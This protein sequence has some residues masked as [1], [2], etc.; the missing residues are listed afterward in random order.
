MKKKILTLVFLAAGVALRAATNDL[1]SLLQQGLFDEEA[2]H[3]LTS[4]IADYQSLATQFDRDRQVAATAIYRLGECYR[5]LGKSNEAVGE[6]QRIIKEFGEQKDLATL[7]QQNLAGLG[8]A[9]EPHFATRLNKLV[10][11]APANAEAGRQLAVV[12]KLQAMQPYDVVQVAPTLLPDATLINLINQYNQCELDRLRLRADHAETNAEVLKAMAIRGVMVDKIYER[13]DGLAKALTIEIAA[14]GYGEATAAPAE[15]T[16]R[17]VPDAE[18]AEIQNIQQMIQNSP[19]LINAPGENQLTPLSKAAA[20]GWLKVAAYLL[21][22]GAEVNAVGGR[23]VTALYEAARAGNRAMVELLLSRGAEVNAG[24]SATTH[25]LNVAA[26][27]GFTAVVEVLLANKADVNALDEF[28]NTPLCRAAANSH[29]KIIQMLLTAG[30]N[31]N[32][33]NKNAL[34]PLMLAAQKNSPDA[35]KLLL[36]AGANPNA[37]DDDG[38]CPLGAAVASGS[39]D[40]VEMLLAAKADPNGGTLDTPLFCAIHQKDVV[41]AELLLKAG[42][43]PNAFGTVDRT[44]VEV[45]SDHFKCTPLYQAI[46]SGQLPMVQLLLKFKADPNNAQ[47]YGRPLLFGALSDTNILETMLNAGATVDARDTTAQQ[48]NGKTLN[49]TP[50]IMAVRD[51]GNNSRS[52]FSADIVEILLRHGANPNLP[53]DAFGEA[54]LYWSAGWGLQ[55]VPNRKI[56]ELLLDYKADPNARNFDGRTLLDGLKLELKNTSASD[57][58]LINDLADL[59]RQHGALDYLPD[60]DHIR[61][62]RLAATSWPVL[63]K[64]TNDWNQFTLL[65]LVAVEC[66]FLAPSPGSEITPRGQI[67]GVQDGAYDFFS[68]GQPLPFPDLTRLRIRRPASDLKNTTEQTVDLAAG[69]QSGD[70]SRDTPLKWADVVEIPEADHPINDPWRGFS[71]VEL[72]NIKKCLTRHIEIIVKGQT[73]AITLAPKFDTG[74]FLNMAHGPT[75]PEISAITEVSFWLG[76]VL[77]QSNL[78]LASSDL[79]QVKVTRPDPATG[80]AR[81]WTVD[82]SGLS[83][84]NFNA[85]DLWLRD[86]DVVKV[87]EKP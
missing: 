85:D 3:D 16:V 61:V 53:D 9:G 63:S 66:H 4:A 78:I 36:A 38:R 40:S 81:V 17:S 50:L 80:K 82:Y 25:P 48:Y 12:K 46:S 28:G 27:R 47:T 5:K 15:P 31:P 57:H 56:V 37:A 23:G 32:V 24:G 13:L 54:P 71:Q 21:D 49:W 64:G 75:G 34:T 69:L 79:S 18:G 51:S 60:Q 76:P 29:A 55:R 83:Q 72:A 11:P 62:G 65:E 73:N 14:P 45:N 58:L 1:A 70:C 86:G 26:D 20:N 59:L 77:R 41:S 7:S 43:N 10:S 33:N 6:Y 39:L 87:P 22:H 74:A 19:D 84:N 44:V 67:Y 8:S 68:K 2:N 42:A 35:V 30:A 52:G